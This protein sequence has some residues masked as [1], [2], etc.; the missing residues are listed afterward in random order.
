MCISGLGCRGWG[1]IKILITHFPDYCVLGILSV[2]GNEGS[3]E[4]LWP[5]INPSTI[6]QNL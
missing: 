4:A 2:S 3:L 5:F 6:A 1:L